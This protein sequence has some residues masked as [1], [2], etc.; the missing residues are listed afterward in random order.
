MEQNICNPKESLQAAGLR[1]TKSRLIVLRTL[2]EKPRPLSIKDLEKHISPSCINYVTL[3]RMMD[4]FTTAG[5]VSKI[6][7]GRGHATFE[8]KNSEEHHH[9]VCT[10]CN[11]IEDFA[12]PIHSKI[13]ERIIK[14]S[15]TFDQLTGHSF[16]LFGLCNSCVKTSANS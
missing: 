8:L 11:K 15:R 16:E 7:L 4:V 14:R 5:I 12:D 9:I 10:D 2:A 1:A 3:Y 13:A 6:E